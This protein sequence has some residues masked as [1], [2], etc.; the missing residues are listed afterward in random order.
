MTF[1]KHELLDGVEVEGEGR[2][3][4]A[5]LL[6]EEGIVEVGPVHRHV[7]VNAALATNRELVAIGALHDGDV[8]CEQREIEEVAPVVRQPR[9]HLAGELRGR[10]GTGHV[11]ERRLRGDSDLGQRLCSAL[12]SHRDLDGLAEPHD[13]PAPRFGAEAQC[14][15]GDV[16]GPEWQQ[17]RDE[18]AAI[19]ADDDAL[20]VGLRPPQR[21][22]R[23]HHRRA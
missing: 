23:P 8:G 15:H 1:T 7:V 2:P 4:P 12:K 13:Q 17:R 22:R 20:V 21:H 18:D 3:L 9:D 10:L 5:A 14:T 16:V 6:A 19:T 11:D